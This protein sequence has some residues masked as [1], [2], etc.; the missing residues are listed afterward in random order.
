[1]LEKQAGILT[2]ISV[3]FLHAAHRTSCH[4]IL[5]SVMC[6]VVASMATLYNVVHKEDS[7]RPESKK[8]RGVLEW[9][10]SDATECVLGWLD[11][12]LSPNEFCDLNQL[13][14]R[15]KTHF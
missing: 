3:D 14:V 10:F 9:A 1:M 4:E 8:M 11:N 6:L 15:I 13:Q 5:E 12:N 7:A 2:K